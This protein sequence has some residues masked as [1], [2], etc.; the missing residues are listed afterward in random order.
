MR[1]TAGLT[2]LLQTNVFERD[3]PRFG[4]SDPPFRRIRTAT[5][6][7]IEVNVVTATDERQENP[8]PEDH[9]ENT[10]IINNRR[11]RLSGGMRLNTAAKATI[12]RPNT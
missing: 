4:G 8:V 5:K 12:V 3:V 7:S 6:S 11:R 10:L 9:E 1:R 2:G